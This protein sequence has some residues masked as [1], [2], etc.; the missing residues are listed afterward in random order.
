MWDDP[1]LSS[2]G[3]NDENDDVGRKRFEILIL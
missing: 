2:G 3:F 1:E